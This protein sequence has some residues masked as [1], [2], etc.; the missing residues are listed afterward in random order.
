ME[1]GSCIQTFSSSFA[2][3]CMASTA[4]MVRLK[5]NKNLKEAKR[6]HLGIEFAMKSA[7]LELNGLRAYY[8]FITQKN[9]RE[10]HVPLMILIDYKYS[11]CFLLSHGFG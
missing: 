4:A 1:S 5:R 11:S 3:I 9:R 2:S 10:L 6:T 7:A 8:K